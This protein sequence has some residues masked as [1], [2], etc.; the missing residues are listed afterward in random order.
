[1]VTPRWVASRAQPIALTD[2]LAYLLRLP[3]LPAAA[4]AVYDVGGPEVLSYRDMMRQFGDLVGR[5]PLIVPVPALTPALSS[6]WL[7]LVTAVP[8]NVARAL[9]DGLA[10]DVLADDAAIRALIPLPLQNYRDAAR[11]ALEAE[12]AEAASVTG[13]R[14]T[15]GSM[16]YRQDRADFAFYAKQMSARAPCAA[17]AAAAWHTV[18]SIGGERGYYFLN[19]LWQARGCIDRLAGGVGMRRGARHATG[20]EVGDE[21]DFWRV[22]DVEPGQRL[23]L[24]AEMSLPGAA[25]LQFEVLPLGPR[26]CELRVT[27]Y[28]HPAGLRGLAY[29]HALA[30]V[31][32]LL[33][34]GMARAMASSAE[35][36]HWAARA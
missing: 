1:M 5:R 12:R 7:D 6:Y 23:T 3:L 16:R 15:E 21:I 11:A 13:H 32:A 9:I 2:V 14:W 19:G 8:A 24:L 17:P 35:R 20:P 26:R 29:W 25:A 33:F 28:F 18:A 10:H 34:P 4:G 36:D 31:H 22:A 30:P 27:A